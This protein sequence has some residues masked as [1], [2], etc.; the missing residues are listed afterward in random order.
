MEKCRKLT[1]MKNRP[2]FIFQWVWGMGGGGITSKIK[3][4]G[5]SVGW[6]YDL[7]T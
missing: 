6:G 7:N 2:E 5:V 4:G 3:V 1:E